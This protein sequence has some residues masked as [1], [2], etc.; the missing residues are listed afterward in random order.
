[1][2]SRAVKGHQPHIQSKD[3]EPLDGRLP[4]IDASKLGNQFI[5]VIAV[6]ENWIIFQLDY[7]LLLIISSVIVARVE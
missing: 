2:E 5:N 1:V 6:S 4:R 3:N 7:P